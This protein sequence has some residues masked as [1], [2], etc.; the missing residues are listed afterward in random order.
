[1][2]RQKLG[3]RN[4]FGC[5]AVHTHSAKVV[6]QLHKISKVPR[7]EGPPVQPCLSDM[8]VTNLERWNEVPQNTR[9]MERG[10]QRGLSPQVV[11]RLVEDEQHRSSEDGT[12]WNRRVLVAWKD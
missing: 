4:M 8:S 9:Q 10:S 3:T 6:R 2:E 7:P 5:T 1:M 12:G 11:Q